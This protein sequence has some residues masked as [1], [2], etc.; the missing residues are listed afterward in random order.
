LP[1][2]IIAI[3]FPTPLGNIVYQ[4]RTARPPRSWREVDPAGHAQPGQL[5]TRT[6]LICLSS[7]GFLTKATLQWSLLNIQRPLPTP[8]RRHR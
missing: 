5:S 8:G 7:A 4:L 2:P 1:S 3:R 6:V